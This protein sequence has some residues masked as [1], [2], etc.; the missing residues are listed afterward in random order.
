MTLFPLLPGGEEIP[1][2][3]ALSTFRVGPAMKPVSFGS[4]RNN[5]EDAAAGQG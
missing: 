2:R 1:S 5:S 4:S 3:R